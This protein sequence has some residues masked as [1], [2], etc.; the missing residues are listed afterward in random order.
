MEDNVHYFT[1]SATWVEVLGFPFLKEP[2]TRLKKRFCVFLDAQMSGY[3]LSSILEPVTT[4]FRV[5]E[6]EKSIQ[7]SGN[8]KFMEVLVFGFLGTENPL[9]FQVTGSPVSGFLKRGTHSRFRIPEFRVLR[10]WHSHRV[11]GS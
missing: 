5:P 9:G 7:V 11:L 1:L 6:N 2:E 3:N 4:G 10:N 8:G